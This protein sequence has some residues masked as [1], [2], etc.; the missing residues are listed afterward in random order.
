M[1]QETIAGLLDN[2]LAAN[3]PGHIPQGVQAPFILFNVSDRDPTR[4]KSGPSE[5]DFIELTV[6]CFADTQAAAET[7]AESVRTYIDFYSDSE[8]TSLTFIRQF[9]DFGFDSKLNM[10]RQEYRGRLIR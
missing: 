10:V 5:V 6:D 7:Y 4:T 3:Y 9:P 2:V 8:I 1:I